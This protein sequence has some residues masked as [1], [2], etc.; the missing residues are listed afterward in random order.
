MPMSK[1][2]SG[3]VVAGKERNWRPV[4]GL[5]IVVVAVVLVWALSMWALSL[6]IRA[7]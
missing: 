5:V 6:G 2:T 7:S 3:V 1:R 4:I